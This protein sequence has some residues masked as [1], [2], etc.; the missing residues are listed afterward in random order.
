M[1]LNEETLREQ[2]PSYLTQPQ[3]EALAAGLREFERSSLIHNFSI[4]QFPGDVLQGDGWSGFQLYEFESGKK[5]K[6]RGLIISNS[7]DIDPSN[8]RDAPI[9]VTFVPLIKLSKLKEIWVASGV[10][11]ERLDRKFEDIRAQRITSF[12]H[13]PI[14]GHL[15][16]E[17]VALLSDAHTMPLASFNG[18]TTSKKLFTLSQVAFYLFLF[19][20]S[21]H[22]CRM[23]EN[24]VR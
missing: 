4:T 12:F 10:T 17:S 24:I 6:V 20:L 14:T 15:E 3:K 23:H 7:C 21:V 16:E 5:R 8:H 1:T 22:Y 9:T 19:K 11:D 13:V 2:I 18:D